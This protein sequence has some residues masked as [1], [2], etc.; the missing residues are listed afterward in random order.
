[1]TAR[2]VLAALALAG[3]LAG[4]DYSR[5]VVLDPDVVASRNARDW[6]VYREPGGAAPAASTATSG[7]PPVASV[8]SAPAASAPPPPRAD[9]DN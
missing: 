5:L 3:T 8:A 7:P 1:M 9:E 6:T 2:S 4:C